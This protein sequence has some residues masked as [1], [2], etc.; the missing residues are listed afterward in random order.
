MKTNPRLG[1]G[2]VLMAATLWGTTGT[3][4]A[5]AGG[6]LP[7]IWFGA[8][9]LLVAAMFFA[10]FAASTGGAR[11]AAWQGLA[12]ADVLGAGLCMAVYNLAFF[13]GVQRTGVAIGTAIALGSGPIWAGLLQA[14]L[15]R[16]PPRLAWWAATAVAVT[17]GVLLSTGEGAGLTQVSAWGVALCLTSGLSYAVYTVLNK[18]MVAA[19]PASTITLAAF[20]V[21]AAR[22]LPAAWLG[23]GAPALGAVDPRAGAYTGIVTAGVAYL[24]FSH[25]LHHV[26]PA[27]AVSLALGEPAVAFAL[28]VTLLGEQTGAAGLAGFALVV[29]GVLGVVRTELRGSAGGASRKFGWIARAD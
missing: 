10:V 20:G 27:T 2:C 9:R 7:A 18:R 12:P 23:S 5:L 21:A 15:H 19:A 13:V 29:A 4:Q 16:A 24:L 26:S 28:A 1:I 25:A 8:L 6:A 17:G 14:A 11:R 3:A 22:A